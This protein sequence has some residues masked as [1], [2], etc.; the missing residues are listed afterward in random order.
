MK[1]TLLAILV[2][3]VMLTLSLPFAK[4]EETPAESGLTA[5]LNQAMQ[6]EQDIR[7][8][9]EDVLNTYPNAR[10]FV[11]LLRSEMA[12]IKLLERVA[13]NNGIALSVTPKDIAVPATMEETLALA[14]QLEQDDIG[15]YE[16]LLTDTTLPQGSVQAFQL[17]KKASERHLSALQRVSGSEGLG[18][19]NPGN[20]WMNGNAADGKE[21]ST[22]SKNAQQPRF[23]R[24][25][26]R[27]SNPRQFFRF[28]R[29]MRNRMQE[30]APRC[31][32]ENCP[33]R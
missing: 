28:N 5:A 9:Y 33:R 11:S 21:G 4:A 7:G 22:D 18:R 12:H 1:R 26:R 10:P 15:L 2:L 8:F 24:G 20:A 32:C 13:K 19:G 31:P 17:L 23:G 6:D 30:A 27:D 14:A 3:A 29:H 25:F 16:Q